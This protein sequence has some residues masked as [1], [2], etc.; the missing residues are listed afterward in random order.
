MKI[1]NTTFTDKKAQANAV[2]NSEVLNKLKD[3]SITVINY[4][5]YEVEKR[6]EKTGESKI[7]TLLT[8]ETAEHEFYGTVSENV[9]ES[10]DFIN[11]TMGGVSPKNP[12]TILISSARSKNDREFLQ[13]SVE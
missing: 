4:V 8:F 7:K 3:N 2:V 6:D 1:I 5:L 11:E 10:W 9:M 13:I 12:I